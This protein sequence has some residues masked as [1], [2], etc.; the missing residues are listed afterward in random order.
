MFGDGGDFLLYISFSA[1]AEHACLQKSTLA[2]NLSPKAGNSLQHIVAA[3]G[4][5]GV[6]RPPLDTS[7]YRAVVTSLRHKHYFVTKVCP[8]V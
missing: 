2:Q 5:S 4:P 8:H 6:R 3:E 1:L 7:N